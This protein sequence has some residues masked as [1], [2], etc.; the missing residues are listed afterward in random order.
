MDVVMVH[1]DL[2]CAPRFAF[3]TGYAMRA[4]REGDVPTW[5]C[6]QQ[7]GDPFYKATAEDFAKYMPGDDAYLAQR[8]LFLMNPAGEDIGSI[9][10]WSDSDFE[11][12]EIGHIHWVAIV[13]AEQGR[14]LGKPMI[15]AACDVLRELGYS[16]A[17]L[18]T[19][20]ERIPALNLYLRC[21]FRPHARNEA[22]REAWRAVA[23]RLK[24]P[25]DL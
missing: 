5:V 20:T 14:G 9:T 24:I 15:S 16:A 19:N 11:G 10:A 18:E 4:Y 22:E 25:I 6:I 3:P 13:A 8:V 12:R 21:G 1:R 7:T 2:S 23:P 17:Y